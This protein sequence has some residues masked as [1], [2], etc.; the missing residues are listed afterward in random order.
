MASGKCSSLLRLR[1]LS[2]TGPCLKAAQR[3]LA[4]SQAG[5]ADDPHIVVHTN[6]YKLHRLDKGPSREVETSRSE[7]LN[8]FRT[9]VTMR[10]YGTVNLRPSRWFYTVK[11]DLQIKSP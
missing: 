9:M 8:M 4:S 6:P 3:A 2:C 10:R 1:S 5:A 7:L 11:T